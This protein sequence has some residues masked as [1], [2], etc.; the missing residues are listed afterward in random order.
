[1]TGCGGTIGH[2]GLDENS[3]PRLGGSADDLIGTYPTTLTPASSLSAFAGKSA[4]G[5]WTLFVSDNAASD[6][7]TLNQWCLMLHG[8][9]DTT[10]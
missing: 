6:L 2:R 1:M 10:L 8:A 7:G 9:A 5:P 3:A 4:S